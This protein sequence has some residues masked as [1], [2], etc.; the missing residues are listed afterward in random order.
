MLLYISLNTCFSSNEV[1]HKLIACSLQTFYFYQ[2]SV[3]YLIL[4]V[5]RSIA[6]E[7][8]LCNFYTLYSTTLLPGTEVIKHIHII[9][10]F[11]AKYCE[12][13]G[14]YWT[15]RFGLS[16]HHKM[17]LYNFQQKTCFFYQS[18]RILLNLECCKHC[19]INIYTI[20][21]PR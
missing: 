17:T 12:K 8:I 13:V 10:I 1:N 6:K 16:C 2:S 21:L 18:T 9:K 19:Q 3:S 7:G 4:I 14:L 5:L 20:L 11:S 15:S